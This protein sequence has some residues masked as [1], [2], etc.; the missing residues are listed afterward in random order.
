M[1]PKSSKPLDALKKKIPEDQIQGKEA[2]H[3]LLFKD[4]MKVS[5]EMILTIIIP[6]ANYVCGRVYCF[7]VVR[8]TDRVSIM[9]VTFCF[10]NNF[11]NH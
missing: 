1:F 7:H 5:L 8:P 2:D 9:S 6:S 11:K 4:V 10:L 3:L